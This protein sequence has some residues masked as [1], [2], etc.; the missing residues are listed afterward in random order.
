MN[1]FN[2]DPCL[3]RIATQKQQFEETDG[4]I[5][6]TILLVD[7][8]LDENI[9]KTVLLVDK[10]LDQQSDEHDGLKGLI[11]CHAMKNIIPVFPRTPGSSMTKK[12]SFRS[13]FAYR[14]QRHEQRGENESRCSCMREE[15]VVATPFTPSC[16]QCRTRH[17]LP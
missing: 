16:C 6:K 17:L 7:K 15:K 12:P 2:D 9:D 11:S 14:I 10:H 1:P 5:D 3:G 8:H 4:N 13:L